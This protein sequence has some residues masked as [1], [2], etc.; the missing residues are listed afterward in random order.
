MIDCNLNLETGQKY[1]KAQEV[2]TTSKVRAKTTSRIIRDASLKHDNMATPVIQ[3]LGDIFPNFIKDITPNVVKTTL[4]NAN[5]S[6]I[7]SPV[8]RAY[9]FYDTVIGNKMPT[10]NRIMRLAFQSF[11]PSVTG[12]GHNTEGALSKQMRLAAQYIDGNLIQTTNDQIGRIK[13]EYASQGRIL[14]EA[15]RIELQTSVWNA[16]NNGTRFPTNGSTPEHRI[17]AIKNE[18]LDTLGDLSEAIVKMAQTAGAKDAN[19]V[20][21][22]I[23]GYGKTDIKP[24]T[25]RQYMPQAWDAEQLHKLLIM[26]DGNTDALVASFTSSVYSAFT[27]AGKYITFRRGD[28]DFV[29]SH[30]RMPT[31]EDLAAVMTHQV[32][33]GDK[34]KTLFHNAGLDGNGHEVINAVRSLERGVMRNGLMRA[35]DL[36]EEYISGQRVV[37]LGYSSTT[38]QIE[39]SAKATKAHTDAV[40]RV[41]ADYSGNTLIDGDY[42]YA[43]LN[44]KGDGQNLA[45]SINR[46]YNQ[47]IDKIFGV[48]RDANGE[49]LTMSQSRLIDLDSPL[50]VNGDHPQTGATVNLA[51]GLT[52]KDL[53]HKDTVSTSIAAFH[54]IIGRTALADEFARITDGQLHIGSRTDFNSVINAMREAFNQEIANIAPDQLE[55]A[56]HAMSEQINDLNYLY[57]RLTG[58]AVGVTNTPEWMIKG[59]RITSKVL[60]LQLL[61]KA[62]L[63]AVTE[64]SKIAAYNGVFRSV[65]LLAKIAARERQSV[66]SETTTRTEVL[67][68]LQIL[69]GNSRHTLDNSIRSHIQAGETSSMDGRFEKMLFKGNQFQNKWLSFMNPVTDMLEHTANAAILG[70]IT[71][72]MVEVGKLRDSNGFISEEK[73]RSV[74]KNSRGNWS[75]WRYV[76]NYLG[77]SEK[78]M[79][80]LLQNFERNTK[81]NRQL[82][83]EGVVDLDLGIESIGDYYDG[84]H[85]INYKQGHSWDDDAIYTLTK[86]VAREGRKTV[87][88][89]VAGEVPRF[90]DN[91][92]GRLV[93]SMYQFSAVAYSKQFLTDLTYFNK[94]VMTA[95]TMEVMMLLAINSLRDK[96]RNNLDARDPRI[97][98]DE[99]LQQYLNAGGRAVGMNSAFGLPLT[100]VYDTT[101][102]V[103]GG[104]GLGGGDPRPI[105]TPMIMLQ[106]GKASGFLPSYYKLM[107]GEQITGTEAHNAMQLLFGNSMP[108]AALEKLISTAAR[109]GELIK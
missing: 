25:E 59:A 109:K 27:K 91:P 40:E 49:I 28:N 71:D 31:A 44:N 57:D 10:Y 15:D 22:G 62:G 53:L 16:R 85:H 2:E 77:V 107:S 69:V 43:I 37:K 94:S 41:A 39:I 1:N 104:S 64:F 17:N 82:S 51:E 23:T 14:N 46:I 67:S 38:K 54:Q 87:Q 108:E 83:A 72:I 81:I 50:V 84:K 98:E 105:P 73:L 47:D 95:W 24:G 26:A 8:D 99:L 103:I 3:R 48:T 29:G 78:E 12:I 74:F 55:S 66:F 88:Q 9:A 19:G 33:Q 35:G 45:T 75:D 58:K 34:G 60:Q 56:R 42:V 5:F 36:T 102:Y 63:S 86:I 13:L 70:K 89:N 101:Q 106:L 6:I 11:S 68:Q 96:M 97:D 30:I 100:A 7:A 52:F 21:R 4:A 18:M 32:M 79:D 65:A 90:L 93:F 20:G 92:I 61:G 80:N 76:Q